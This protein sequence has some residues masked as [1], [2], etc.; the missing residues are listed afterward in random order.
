MQLLTK[1]VRPSG[2]PHPSTEAGYGLRL[3]TEARTWQTHA[4]ALSR[5]RES[6]LSAK[7]LDALA[8]SLEH[9]AS[10]FTVPT[11]LSGVVKHQETLHQLLHLQV[12]KGLRLSASSDGETIGVQCL[13]AAVGAIQDKHTS[14]LLPLLQFGAT[15]H[16]LAVTGG[17]RDEGFLG[18]NVAVCRTTAAIARY[19]AVSG[20]GGPLRTPPAFEDVY[21]WRDGQR[22]PRTSL[23]P[24]HDLDGAVLDWGYIGSAPAEL[25]RRILCLN[26]DPTT[27][28]RL[29]H[30]FE[31]DIVSV[32]PE[33]GGIVRGISVA[34]WL[35]RRRA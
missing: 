2:V 16:L 17:D 29:M 34:S 25:A 15:L 28:L 33:D 31:E 11:K 8:F 18:L 12:P 9:R 32:L 30:R 13:G 24:L 22:S 27:A 20:D 23:A 14:W 21:L 3:L 1:K 5:M 7:A 35:H 6:T 10:S 26:T 4:A 19:D